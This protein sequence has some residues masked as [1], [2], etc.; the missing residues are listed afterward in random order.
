MVTEKKDS[1][2]TCFYSVILAKRERNTSPVQLSRSSWTLL[3]GDR[4]AGK[5]LCGEGSGVPGWQ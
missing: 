4:V 3:A 5:Q 2:L 1:L